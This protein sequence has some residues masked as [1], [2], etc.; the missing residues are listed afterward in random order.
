LGIWAFNSL[1]PAE[2]VKAF[3]RVEKI[4]GSNFFAEYNWLR[5]DYIVTLI[6]DLNKILEETEKGVKSK[7]NFTP[8]IVSPIRTLCFDWLYLR[9]I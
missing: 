3:N 9:E 4:F 2:T 8:F 1:Y 6:V 5:G 7:G